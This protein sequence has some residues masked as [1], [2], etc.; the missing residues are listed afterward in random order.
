M[1]FAQ[2]I[3]RNTV[4]VASVASDVGFNVQESEAVAEVSAV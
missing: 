2:T 4:S 1:S 3:A